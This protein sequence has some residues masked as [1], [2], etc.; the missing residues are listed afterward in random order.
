[1]IQT[2]P[3]SQATRILEAL[4]MV[5]GHTVSNYELANMTPRIMAI[6]KRISDLRAEGHRIGTIR[7]KFDKRK[8]F[9]VL[10]EKSGQPSAT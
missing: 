3:K 8:F 6:N 4:Q 2:K 1:M 10:L 9:Y 5:Q 7:C